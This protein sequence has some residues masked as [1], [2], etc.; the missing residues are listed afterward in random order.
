MQKKGLHSIY[1]KKLL[2]LTIDKALKLNKQYSNYINYNF[3]YMNT[4]YV[5]RKIFAKVEPR[6]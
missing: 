1:L 5:E 6:T 3:I 2:T 4:K